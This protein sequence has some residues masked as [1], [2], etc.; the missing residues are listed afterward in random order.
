MQFQ[1]EIYAIRISIPQNISDW[2]NGKVNSDMSTVYTGANRGVSQYL[3]K[4]KNKISE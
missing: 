2:E 4:N 1:I 3:L